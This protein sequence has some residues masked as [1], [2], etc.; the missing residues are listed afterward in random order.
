MRV[1]VTKSSLGRVL[2]W[3]QYLLFA[4]AVSLLGYCAFVLVD[5]WVF[6]KQESRYLDRLL[7]DSRTASG[8]APRIGSPTSPTNP[9]AA[10]AD[11][12]I[13]RIEIPRLR[14]ST[15]VIEGID[16]TTLRRAVGHFPG[17]ALPGQ[18][19]NVCI[20]GH[21]DTFFRPLRGI[22]KGDEITVTTLHGSS[23]YRVDF[24]KVIKPEDIEVLDRS[25]DALLT[26]VTCYPF[27]YVGAAPKRFVVRAHKIPG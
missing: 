18:P 3:T 11:G 16:T 20:A 15:V 4:C 26:L 25:D 10:T 21:R 5:A 17:T 9:P 13:G 22:R 8:G 19:G 24:T 12:L 14:L 7:H 2:R 23:R 6:Q 1:V 27:D